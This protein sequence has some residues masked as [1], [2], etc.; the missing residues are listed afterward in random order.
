VR[1]RIGGPC[2]VV[3]GASDGGK[4]ALVGV[5]SNELVERGISVGEL[6]S[7]GARIL[8]GGGSLDPELAQAGGPRGDQL[9]TALDTVRDES[10]RALA[11]L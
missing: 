10:G 9:Q 5:V 4:G 11:E 1:D 3:L 6:L 7:G 2:L 8:G